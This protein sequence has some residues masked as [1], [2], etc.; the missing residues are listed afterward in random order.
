M[1]MKVGRSW[2]RLVG[3]GYWS[4]LVMA[5]RKLLVEA[6]YGRAEAGKA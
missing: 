4:G 1:L 5:G 6:S 3:V 2:Q